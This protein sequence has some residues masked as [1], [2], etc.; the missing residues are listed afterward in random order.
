MTA[1]RAV[2]FLV[3]YLGLFP[4]GHAVTV[5]YISLGQIKMPPMFGD[6]YLPH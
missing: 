6:I 2:R 5:V 3:R 4:V 1:L